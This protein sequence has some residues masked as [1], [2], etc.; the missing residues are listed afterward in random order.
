M[1]HS[2]ASFERHTMILGSLAL[3]AFKSG[4]RPESS[5]L[6]AGDKLYCVPMLP[7][8]S[9]NLHV[10]H[11]RNYIISDV[12]C[13]YYRQQGF[14]TLMPMGWDAFGIPAENAALEHSVHPSAWVRNNVVQMKKLM[15]RANLS[16]DWKRELTTSLP[17]Y[18][19]WTQ[20]LLLKLLKKGLAYK[21]VALVNWDPVDETVLSD[22]Q[23]I[24]GRGWRSGSYVLKRFIDTFFLKIREHAE[25]LLI[26][27]E[28]LSWPSNVKVMQRNWINRKAGM[29]ISLLCSSQH[30]LRISLWT[31]DAS[32]IARPII[33]VGNQHHWLIKKLSSVNLS[34]GQFIRSQD[35]A[36]DC[37]SFSLKYKSFSVG[38]KWH[39]VP[40]SIKIMVCA[41]NFNAESDMLFASPMNKEGA[42]FLRANGILKRTREPRTS[43]MMTK[44]KIVGSLQHFLNFIL[45]KHSSGRARCSYGMRDW[46]ISRQR[47][48]GTPIPI[49]NCKRCSLTPVNCSELPVILSESD[50][51]IKR[52]KMKGGVA[53]NCPICGALS[54]RENDTL[55]TFFDSSWYFYRYTNWNNKSFFSD[56]RTLY[57]LPV[58]LYVGGIEHSI[59]HLLYLRFIALAITSIGFLSCIEP[60]RKLFVQGPVVGEAFYR[61]THDGKVVWLEPESAK[62]L[63]GVNTS[64]IFS[65]G[66]CKMS[67]SKK[68]GY[69]PDH[70]ISRYGS[71]A[72]RL[73]VLSLSPPN[74]TL[75]WSTDSINGVNKFVQK[76]LLFNNAQDLSFCYHQ[77]T[78]IAASASEIL[79]KIG[80]E[81][82][83]MSYN[84]I[85]SALINVVRIIKDALNDKVC[86]SLIIRT[87]RKLVSVSFPVLPNVSSFLWRK[88][89]NHTKYGLLHNQS[90]TMM[91]ASLSFPD[92]NEIVLQINGKVKQKNKEGRTGSL[93][94]RELCCLTDIIMIIKFR[95]NKKAEQIWDV[96]NYKNRV[97]SV[98]TTDP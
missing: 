88:H 29:E 34:L 61:R 78:E 56:Q 16:I 19:T 86:G 87:F 47:F 83:T 64:K 72:V 69:N 18:Y 68:N 67:K 85:F 90:G 36:T 6:K 24:D 51:V 21:Q 75:Q 81:Y 46:N 30:Q 71:D 49:V 79:E 96:T 73:F 41:S 91:P 39:L 31:E 70:L 97:V 94:E 80:I 25:D 74:Q 1:E 77:P 27:L 76:L 98:R 57:W 2:R 92:R 63:E 42:L 20:W 93:L 54:R 60:I 89:N 95:M 12:V 3:R 35:S 5:E 44:P 58:D 52:I 82:K 7:Y 33:L 84:K 8:P 22:E 55:D 11:L 62:K 23:V 14:N 53:C 28:D 45:R 48:W 43:S 32:V 50:K 4:R 59:L 13:R 40:T 17:S 65:A 9:G 15:E 38:M 37:E 10:G 26:N 66:K